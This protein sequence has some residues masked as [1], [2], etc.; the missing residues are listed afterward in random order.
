VSELPAELIP[1]LNA[2]VRSRI[3]LGLIHAEP[4]RVGPAGAP[5]LDLARRFCADLAERHA[6]RAPSEIAGLAPARE[7]Y[8]SFGID[9]TRTRPSS[10]SLLRRVVRGHPLPRILNAVDVAN[11]CGLKFL[12][13]IGLYDVARI[14]GPVVLRPG[15]PGE[16]YP[17]IRK[18]DVHLEGRPVLA[19]ERGPFGNPTSDSARTAVGPSTRSLWMV[20]FAPAGFDADRMERHVATAAEDLRA[21]L[22]PPGEAVATSTG[23]LP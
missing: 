8:R 17:G 14:E 6:G 10:E 4:V 16:S 11:L 2:D 13:P 3:R 12:L 21:H 7:L 19:D 1:G 18:A 22:A 15:A 23:V 5:F 9:P 20:V